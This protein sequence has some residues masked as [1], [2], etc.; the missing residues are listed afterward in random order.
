MTVPKASGMI[1]GS[2][3]NTTDMTPTTFTEAQWADMI[4]SA[5]AF[6]IEMNADLDMF[7]DWAAD[8]LQIEN[9][10]VIV[11]DDKRWDE[12]VKVWE[13]TDENGF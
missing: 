9:I 2:N 13:E 7:I 10:S 1:W 4:A 6:I 3:T 11:D 12:M 8:Q 5:P